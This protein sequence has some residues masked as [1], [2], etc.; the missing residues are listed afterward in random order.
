M[1]TVKDRL[2]KLRKKLCKINKRVKSLESCGKTPK[3]DEYFPKLTVYEVDAI[4][5][6]TGIKQADRIALKNKLMELG[7]ITSES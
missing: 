5:T 6:L 1:S 7:M 3:S 2:K 4:L